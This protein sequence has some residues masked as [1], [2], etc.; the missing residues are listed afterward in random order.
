MIAGDAGH[1]MRVGWFPKDGYWLTCSCE[2]EAFLGEEAPLLSNVIAVG[3]QH[4]LQ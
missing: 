3:R 2:H 1:E 4:Q